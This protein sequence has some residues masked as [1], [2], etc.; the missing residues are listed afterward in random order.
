MLSHL[1]GPT[2]SLALISL[3][4]GTG[5]VVSRLVILVPATI[6]VFGAEYVIFIAGTDEIALSTPLVTS[7]LVAFSELAYASFTFG[8][9]NLVE[10]RV[11]NHLLLRVIGLALVAFVVSLFLLGISEVDSRG[12]F[13]IEAIGATA[14]V[15]ALAMTATVARRA[16]IGGGGGR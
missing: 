8:D 3:L 15:L 9:L 16:G 4:L 7:G 5:A 13:L 11:V 2:L 1:T 6:I 10:R 12:G 14:A